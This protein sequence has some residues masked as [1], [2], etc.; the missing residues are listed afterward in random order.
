[1]MRALTSI[2]LLLVWGCGGEGNG[3]EPI[4]A[5]SFVSAGAGGSF[6]RGGAPGD[7]AEDGADEERVVE[8]ADIFRFAGD[9]LYVLNQFRG[10]FIFDVSDPDRPRELGRVAFEGLPLEM[11]VRGT[12]V[13]AIL[14]DRW[15]GMWYGGGVDVAEGDAALALELPE[16]YGSRLVG[17]DVSDP[18]R[19]EVVG[20][21]L[22]DGSVSDSRL[23]GDVIY[24]AAN[25]W[26][27]WGQGGGVA[28]VDAETA[29][30]T[31]EIVL[32]SVD[33]SN[34]SR[35]T[36]VDRE[37]IEGSGFFVHASDE[38]FL[39][40]GSEWDGASGEQTRLRYVD[41]SS[42]DGKMQPRGTVVVPGSMQ[43]DLAMDLYEGQLRILTREWTTSLTKL[44]VFDATEPDELP[45]LGSLDYFYDGSLFGTTFDGDR[46]YMVHYLRIDPLEVVDLSD[47]T[48]PAIAGILEMPGW[49]ERIAP[50]GDRLVGL[51]IDDSEGTRRVSVSLFDVSDPADPVR[52]DQI[53]SGLD[54]S[55]S[56][57][58]WERK[59]WTVDPKEG[60]ILFPYSGWNEA[61][62]R[63][64]HA[65]GILELS[66]D[67]LTPRGEVLA[68]APVERG[69]IHDDHVYAISQAAVQVVDLTDRDHPVATATVELARSVLDYA[70]ADRAGAELVQPGLGYWSWWGS[71]EPSMLRVTALASP[72]A[73]EALAE[74][75]LP[76][77]AQTLF[78]TGDLVVALRLTEGCSWR[79]CGQLDGPTATVV[80]L[81]RPSEPRVVRDL[82]L[83]VDPPLPEGIADG[84]SSWTS[85]QTRYGAPAGGWF[86][87]TPTIDLGGGL[88]G[89]LRIETTSCWRIDACRAVGIEPQPY[90]GGPSVDP[91]E[92]DPEPGTG[93]ER[94]EE[95]PD[96]VWGSRTRTDL[97]VLDLSHPAE[98][99]VLEP[100]DLGE[101]WA[102]SP[103]AQD[104]MLVWS[105]S[106]EAGD[107][108][109]GRPQV[110]WYMERL[111]V[112][113][114]G[115]SERLGSVNVPG[116]V[117]ALRGGGDELLTLDRQWAPGDGGTV[118]E[119]WEQGFELWLNALELV[120]DVAVR[121]AHLRL[122]AEAGSVAIAGDRAYAVRTELVETSPEVWTNQP[123]LAVIDIRASHALSFTYDQELDARWWWG[124][125]A[126]GPESLA[127]SAGWYGGLALFDRGLVDEPAFRRFVPT[128][129]WA[130]SVVQEGDT[131]F[132]CS[133]PW[134]IQ[135]IEMP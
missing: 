25:R 26:S 126:V 4:G 14:G 123:R 35:M 76:H 132:L 133:G 84:A 115:T 74:M 118:T 10:L 134:G 61:E 9:R 125:A 90:E 7:A 121:T 70:R 83:P 37:T 81:E 16:P 88:F 13:Y 11:Y 69:A 86:G 34:A 103:F 135:T 55:W 24:V 6:D 32:T 43:E 105:R 82:P 124:V 29:E 8:E 2:T 93:D 72:D 129:G 58:S 128:V 73:S 120:G 3:P 71:G 45:L 44:H 99:R 79:D 5:T 117:I 85:W 1:M 108:E 59:A 109:R 53:T 110:R 31:A 63:E 46:L 116:A 127:L 89:L 96:Y 27:W 17:I 122:G 67:E 62:Q 87:G 92:P 41:I 97:L 98:P 50:L 64:I 56:M 57:A 23:V 75:A 39:V 51:G 47:P 91:S 30:S 94:D 113:A 60:L 65:L 107:D 15:G 54:W 49:V 104:G 80:S 38:A 78:A 48:A 40:A 28:V 102:Q 18:A 100:I 66:L 130:S 21:V 119:W 131:L 33:V 68:A 95:K 36:E 22:L 52:L 112:E 114:D 77:A 20:E 42:P 106:V 101:G 19:P 12:T 111:Q